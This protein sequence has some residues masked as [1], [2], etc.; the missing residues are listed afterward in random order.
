M[1]GAER[2]RVLPS[3]CTA[4]IVA[5]S[6]SD[7]TLATS[8]ALS[9]VIVS[10]ALA[11]AASSCWSSACAAAEVDVAL[12]GVARPGVAG[13]DKEA[14]PGVLRPLGFR[15]GAGAERAERAERAKHTI[16]QYEDVWRATYDVWACAVMSA[17]CGGVHITLCCVAHGCCMYPSS[18]A[19][20]H[21]LAKSGDRE[22][23]SE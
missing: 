10:T 16:V 14:P 5:A 8:A 22:G 3:A 20:R 7:A 18:S 1:G 19:G 11:F 6:S 9:A 23:G 21:L 12:P 13:Y 15:N 4:A 17:W 2:T